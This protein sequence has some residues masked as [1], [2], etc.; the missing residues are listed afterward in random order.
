MSKA[1][2]TYDESGATFYY[3]V[4]SFLALILVPSTYY[5]WPREPQDDK[6]SKADCECNGCQ[7]KRQT[8]NSL[9]KWKRS[10]RR[11]VRA[12]LIAGWI[13]FAIVSYKC[14]TIKHEVPTWD[15]FEILGVREGAS[16]IDIKKAYRALSLIYHPD[17]ETGDSDRFVQI[18]K[19][20]N[21]L[22]D[23]EARK[24]WEM[25]GDPDGP[26]TTSFGIALPSWIVE[27]ENSILVLLVYGL[28]FMVALPV[29]VGI[30]WY[31]SVKYGNDKVLISTSEVYF[32]FI[33][34]TPN[35][36]LKRAIMIV[37][38]SLEFA[39]TH[40]PEVVERPTDNQEVPRL[41]RDLPMLGEKN[42]ETPLCYSYSIKTRAL[43]HAHLGRMK[44]PPTT[45]EHDRWF[46]VRKCPYLIQE[47][48]QCTSQ[49]ITLAYS[50]R[51]QN[52]PTLMTLE[53]GMKLS[54]M[55]VQ[56]LWEYQS[57]LLQLPHL[58]EDH[59]RQWER[60]KIRV[61]TIEQFVRMKDSDRRDALKGVTENQYEDIKLTLASMPYV[62]IKAKFEVLDDEE[63]HI[64]TAGAIVTIT[65]DL[66]RRP[67]LTIL[68]DQDS[69]HNSSAVDEILPPPDQDLEDGGDVQ[70]NQSE[71]SPDDSASE[72]SE[73][74]IENN[75]VLRERNVKQKKKTK[76]SGQVS[77]SKDDDSKNVS[78][79]DKTEP[80]ATSEEEWDKKFHEKVIKKQKVF[81][82]K[83]RISHTVH[84]PYF[85]DDKQE[86][87]WLY[88]VDKKRARLITAP[89]LI[90]NLIK[91]EVVELKFTAPIKPGQYNYTIILRSD[92]YV[93]CLVHKNATI[94]VLPAKEYIEPDYDIPDDDAE[95]F[96]DQ[97]S[98]VSDPD[99]MTDTDD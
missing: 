39:K 18:T 43:M 51:I 52:L 61:R 34:K 63:P 24:N 6:K 2:F 7:T 49:L 36:A 68:D 66:T 92:S 80:S 23:D 84:C 71:D 57:P 99:L 75:N 73:V 15:P 91:H 81:E 50:G 21:A 22:T 70:E 25:Y 42:K 37:A 30:W 86:F 94:N 38:A 26:G 1:K 97:D 72:H 95:G 46:V 93:D 45:L 29:S 17:K 88:M 83:P 79:S 77:G 12:S 16:A 32:Y 59:L 98:A 65:I 78:K 48:V 33:H 60:K 19:A 47:F 82:S 8:L 11:I 4:L 27:K 87:W 76:K 85:P 56:A 35:M 5:C 41:M 53:N 54:G 90:T 67:I 14:A 89:M 62:S 10:R 74:E 13:L 9:N 96:E 20:Y 40:N 28:I 3:F 55:I 44:L 69:K 31:R 58:T 64:I